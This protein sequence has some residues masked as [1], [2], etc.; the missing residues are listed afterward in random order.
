KALHGLGPAYTVQQR[1]RAPI[2]PV[3]HFDHQIKASCLFP[4]RILNPEV[5]SRTAFCI[6]SE[7]L[8]L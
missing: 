6:S 7:V 4:G 1:C 3:G 8:T 2:L 5:T